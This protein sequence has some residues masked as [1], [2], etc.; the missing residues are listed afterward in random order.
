[1]PPMD[2][3]RMSMTIVS[4]T[5]DDIAPTALPTSESSLIRT[6]V[7]NASPTHGM[8]DLTGAPMPMIG[9]ET[10]IEQE[11]SPSRPDM[12]FERR[13]SPAGPSL[14]DRH[15]SDISSSISSLH[16]FSLMSCLHRAMNPSTDISAPLDRYAATR[17]DASRSYSQ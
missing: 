10:L 6:S 1:M 15:S 14:D 3:G 4:E 7:P 9:L 12:A 5:E 11:Y 13:S 16:S 2:F 17:R 8:Y